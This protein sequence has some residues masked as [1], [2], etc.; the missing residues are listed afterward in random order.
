MS[1]ER[2]CC[3]KRARQSGIGPLVAVEGVNGRVTRIEPAVKTAHRVRKASLG[4]FFGEKA[5]CFPLVVPFMDEDPPVFGTASDIKFPFVARGA[6]Q[7]AVPARLPE[8]LP[9]RAPT[10]SVNSPGVVISL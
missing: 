6:I 1:L 8:V 4:S 3:L 9:L 5:G 10:I 7:G 2:G